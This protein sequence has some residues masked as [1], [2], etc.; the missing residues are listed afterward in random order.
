MVLS[1]VSSSNFAFCNVKFL[2]QRVSNGS[3]EADADL[4]KISDLQNALEKQVSS[5]YV[6]TLLFFQMGNW[7]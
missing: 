7:T 1:S 5:S 3:L 4:S 6:F 2:F